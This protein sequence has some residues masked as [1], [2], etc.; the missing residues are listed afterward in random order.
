MRLT[1]FGIR[2]AGVI[3]PLLFCIGCG[4]AQKPAGSAADTSSLE[5]SGKSEGSGSDEPAAP[6]KQ[7]SAATDKGSDAPA[8]TPTKGVA[9]T[10]KPAAQAAAD[11]S[12][13]PAAYHPTPSATGN[14]DGKPFAPKVAVSN[15][16]M[17]KDGRLLLSITEAADCSATPQAGQGTL[18]L[19]VEWKD[20]YKT[21][22]GSLKKA[23]KPGG[24]EVGFSRAGAGGKGTLAKGFKPTGRV[25][26]VKAPT[27]ANATGKIKVDLQSGDFILAGDLDVLLCAAA[28]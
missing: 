4:G 12:S 22:L 2:R 18:S 13:A 16:A 1:V 7:E 15:A 24:G 20:G 3:L 17:Q 9:D 14:I 19:L 28:K 26:V 6:S 11:T 8:P 27:D 23:T 25:T 21:D 10:T 5:P